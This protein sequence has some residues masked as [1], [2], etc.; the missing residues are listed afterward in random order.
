MRSIPTRLRG[1]MVVLPVLL[2]VSAGC[3]I[4][5]ADLAEKET[6]EWRKSYE[7]RPGGRVEIG[8]V[9]GKIDVKT[10]E[11]NTVEIVARKTAR[12]ANVEAAKQTLARIDIRETSSADEV[13]IDTRFDRPSGSLFNSSNWSVEYTVRVPASANVNLSTTNGG[14][15]VSGITG[16]VVAEATNGGIK[17]RDIAG[18][19]EAT[20]TNGGLEVDLLKVDEGGVKLECTNGGITLGLPADAKATVSARAT[21]GGI[22]TGGFSVMSRGEN[23]RRRLDAD[24]NGGGPRISLE[25]TNGGVELVKR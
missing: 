6:A 13:K 2:V 23:S 4:A 8:N 5:M 25:C 20:T 21:N 10:G 22:D 18:K 12:A 16:Q 7:L 1:A 17:A 3:D 14:V 24:L 11:G 19:I 15:E 9:N